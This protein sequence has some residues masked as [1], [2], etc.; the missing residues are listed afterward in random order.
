MLILFFCPAYKAIISELMKEKLKCYQ[1]LPFTYNSQSNRKHALK[2][3]LA[4]HVRGQNNHSYTN[5][6][7]S[8]NQSILTACE[9]LL[10]EVT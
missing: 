3:S 7:I 10:V 6:A 9:P 1:L 2:S 8:D 5:K 4:F